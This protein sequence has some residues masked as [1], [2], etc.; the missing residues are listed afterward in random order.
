M[1]VVQYEH[2]LEEGRFVP[3][4]PRW[5]REKLRI[6]FPEVVVTPVVYTSP[7]ESWEDNP[8]GI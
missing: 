6:M 5:A 8:N 3:K 7:S 4:V 2:V 1:S